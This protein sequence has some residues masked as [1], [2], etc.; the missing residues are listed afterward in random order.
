MKGE[1][2]LSQQVYFL[3]YLVMTL[4]GLS[5]GIMME[6]LYRKAFPKRGFLLG[7]ILSYWFLAIVICFPS[8]L[9]HYRIW[10][11][12]NLAANVIG[13]VG[14]NIYWYRSN[15]KRA[16]L[17]F[18]FYYATATAAELLT[19]LIKLDLTQM[20]PDWTKTMIIP[21]IMTMIL[22]GL[23][24][25][26]AVGFS[27]TR[28]KADSQSEILLIIWLST[29]FLFFYL[30]VV[31]NLD[32][33]HST[34][35]NVQTLFGTLITSRSILF[36]ASLLSFNVVN[37]KSE[38]ELEKSIE[39]LSIQKNIY[40]LNHQNHQQRLMILNDCREGVLQLINLVESNRFKD[41]IDL[42]SQEMNDSTRNKKT[43]CI[44]RVVNAIVLLKEAH[45]LKENIHFSTELRIPEK[46]EIDPL[47]LCRIFGNLLD[48]AIRTCIQVQQSPCSEKTRTSIIL[49]GRAV[50]DLLVITC[51]NTAL[52]NK[53]KKIYGH[54]YGQQILQSVAKKY[55]GNFYGEYNGN[56]SYEAIIHLVNQK[57]GPDVEFSGEISEL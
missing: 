48:N 49:K 51:R 18:F 34:K 22:I 33:D 9:L 50:H 29:A 21:F 13:I 37:Q 24:A 38:S 44:N 31:M 4:D 53:E 32:F 52:K 19:L 8:Y 42:T 43:I 26:I 6:I 27:L 35:D 14:L 56:H 46:L 17:A 1:D 16:F 20:A 5:T 11:M 41:A 25:K 30:I 15:L 10:P 55:D 3:Q 54:G 45:A 36:A 28:K 12:I 47:D 39:L 2:V 23:I 40:D 7:R 57:P